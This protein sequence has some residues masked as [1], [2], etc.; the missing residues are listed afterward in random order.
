MPGVA[1]ERRAGGR[2]TL[3]PEP[4]PRGPHEAGP[5]AVPGVLTQGDVAA[6]A[7]S[8]LEAQRVSGAIPWYAGGDM[9]CWD[10]VE[11]AMALSAAREWRAAEGAYAWLAAAQRQDGSWPRRVRPG[12]R[13]GTVLDPAADANHCAYVAVGVWH[14]ILCTGDVAFATRM[15]PVVRRAVR[16]VLAL[17]APG[18]QV[19]WTRDRRGRAAPEALLAGCSSITHSLRCAVALADLVGH[20]QPAWGR[21][22][23]RLATAVAHRPSAFEDRR[24]YSMDWY[25]PVLAGAVRGEP[26]AA[27]LEARWHEFVVPGLGVRCVADR[28]WVTGAETCELVLSLDAIGERAAAL[29]LLADMQHLRDRDGAYWTGYVFADGLYWPVERSTWTSA[30][31][32]LAA[33]TLSG[34]S[35]GAGIFRC[36][37]GAGADRAAVAAGARPANAN[38]VSASPAP[39]ALEYP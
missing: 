32:I 36:H 13:T 2:T 15:W 5:P 12:A 38:R 33:D 17:Q 26:A 1:A 16:F 30:A 19:R 27:R 10:H 39:D 35:G 29:R 34:A 8:I 7:A 3:P 6:S 22:A 25:Y 9:D 20:P 21:A 14:H 28:P 24:R 23:D 31:V 18:G 4:G 11:S 37:G